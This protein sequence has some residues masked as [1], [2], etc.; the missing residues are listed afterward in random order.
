MYKLIRLFNQNRRKVFI[1][2]LIIVFIIVSI[3]L[4]DYFAKINNENKIQNNV[5]SVENVLN[6]NRELLSD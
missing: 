1:I 5:N 4:L 3:Q 6:N 2:I